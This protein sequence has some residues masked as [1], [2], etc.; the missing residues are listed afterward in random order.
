MIFA[1]VVAFFS[2]MGFALLFHLR[3]KLLVP[4][5]MGGMLSV[6]NGEARLVDTTWE[7][8]D[9][10]DVERA[11]A[12]LARAETML[13]DPKADDQTR[14]YALARQNRARVRLSVAEKK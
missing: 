13:A 8:A 12:S 14:T 4:A 6:M 2:T 1:L 10:I 7:W 11:K 5:C 9:Q 3:P